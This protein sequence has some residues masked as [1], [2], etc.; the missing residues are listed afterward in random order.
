MSRKISLSHGITALIIATIYFLPVA[1]ARAEQ[2]LRMAY[3]SDSPGS[4]APY[5]IAKDAGLFKK[6][7]IDAELI[8]ING[9]T[10]SIQSLIAGDVD[11]VGAV[12][13]SAINGKL[14]GG[15]IVIVDSLVNNLPYYIIG[16]PN[17]KSPE[18]LKGRK[19][20]R[21]HV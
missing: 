8:F 19:I 10:R 12:G 6:Y 16:N 21:A 1:P 5:W 7:G 18:D 14:A 2:K 3:V 4:S 13:T 20:G 11:F 17:I 9:S 15:D